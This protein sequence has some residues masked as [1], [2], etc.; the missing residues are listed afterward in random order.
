[1]IK[2][3]VW[4]LLFHIWQWLRTNTAQLENTV[5]WVCYFQKV[6]KPASQKFKLCINGCLFIK[7]GKTLYDI[8]ETLKRPG[9]LIRHR[10]CTH[11]SIT[12]Q[13]QNGKSQR[14]HICNHKF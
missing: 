8:S 1:M 4:Y 11:K 6:T 13:L 14:E 12:R 5:L 3:S 10:G 9:G 2:G 7:T